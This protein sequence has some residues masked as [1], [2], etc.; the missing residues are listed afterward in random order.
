MFVIPSQSRSATALPKESLIKP[1]P[2]GDFPLGW[3]NI[4]EVDKRDGASAGGGAADG[5]SFH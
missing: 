4:Y 3:E 2:L 5:E 1:R